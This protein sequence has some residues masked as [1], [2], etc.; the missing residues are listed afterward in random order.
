MLELNDQPWEDQGSL[1]DPGS[2]ITNTEAPS[3]DSCGSCNV[4][5]NGQCHWSLENQWL[6]FRLI[7]DVLNHPTAVST[8][9][10]ISWRQGG[11]EGLELLWRQA[12]M[13][14]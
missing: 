7:R 14:G 13:I 5:N 8:W 3:G 11:K 1:P 10:A 12:G 6:L 2:G 9:I 4:Y